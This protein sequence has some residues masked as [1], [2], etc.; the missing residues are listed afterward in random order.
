MIKDVVLKPV[1]VSHHFAKINGHRHCD[2]EDLMVLVCHMIM[3]NHVIK[4]LCEFI[5]GSSSG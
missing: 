2:S 5:G 4:M 3:Q 1:M